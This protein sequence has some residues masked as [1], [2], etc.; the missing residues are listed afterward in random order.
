MCALPTYD[1]LFGSLN[2]STITSRMIR[3]SHNRLIPPNTKVLVKAPM[4]EVLRFRRS[5]NYT[6]L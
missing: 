2:D 5:E 4:R 6:N 3:E 1:E